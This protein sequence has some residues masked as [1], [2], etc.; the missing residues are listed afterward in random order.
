MKKL[1]C[2]IF[3]HNWLSHYQF[4]SEKYWHLVEWNRYPDKWC[5]DCGELKYYGAKIINL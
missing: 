4:L 5:P 2:K 1:L 3:G